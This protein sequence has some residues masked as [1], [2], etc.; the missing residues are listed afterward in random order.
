M[1]DDSISSSYIEIDSIEIIIESEKWQEF[2]NLETIAKTIATK[3]LEGFETNNPSINILFC[4]DEKIRELNRDFRGKDKPTNVLSFPQSDDSLGLGDIAIAYETCATEAIEQNKTLNDHISHL[5]IHGIL[6]LLG[7]DHET[8]E[9]AEEMER[10][11][12]E[13][14][15]QFGISNPYEIQVI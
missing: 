1:E 6:H 3:T 9:E 8:E 10:I 15:L 7:Y 14:L 5:L 2:H 11:E 13:V 12:I 4:D